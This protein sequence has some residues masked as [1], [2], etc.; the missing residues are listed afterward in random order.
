M[1]KKRETG[2]RA[3]DKNRGQGKVFFILLSPT[4]M[5]PLGM[6]LYRTYAAKTLAYNPMITT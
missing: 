2:N 3:S 5:G 4:E 6:L 1:K